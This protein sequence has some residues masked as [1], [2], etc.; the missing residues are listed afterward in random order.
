MKVYKFGGASLKDKKRSLDIIVQ[1]IEQSNPNWQELVIVVSAIDKTTNNLEKLID[2]CYNNRSNKIEIYEKIK[3]FHLDF[4]EDCFGKNYYIDDIYLYFNELYNKTCS[5]N[6]IEDYDGF[7]DSIV[8]YG[9]LLSSRIVSDYLKKTK[10]K[11]NILFV[12]I[13]NHLITDNNHRDAKI[14]FI[15]SENSIKNIFYKKNNIYVTQGYI[16]KSLEGKTTTLGREGSDYSA[17]SIANLLNASVILWKDVPGF[18]TSDPNSSLKKFAK[19]IDN[20]SYELAL[21]MAFY[22]AKIIHPKTIYPLKEKNLD[23]EI[24]PFNIENGS[25]TL[26]SKFNSHSTK[27]PPI[28]IIKEELLLFT[29]NMKDLSFIN[30]ENIAKILSIFNNNK[31]KIILMQ[32][33]SFGFN[34]VCENDEK[35]NLITRLMNILSN[36]YTTKNNKN[37]SLLTTRKGN[38]E[39]IA[40]DV[41]KEILENSEILLEQ[42]SRNVSQFLFRQNRKYSN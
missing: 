39:E 15:K 36:N 25:G 34:V 11:K 42:H 24:K 19:K 12:D 9:E 13:R 2:A 20:L 23:L 1:H 7:Y 16:G 32:N 35:T 38:N 41:N 40:E 30:I 22:G 27:L 33:S 31:A 37:L 5:N 8:C 17:S 29:I 21:D 28:F 3:N 18:M 6:L 26:I 14:N 4:I 10:K